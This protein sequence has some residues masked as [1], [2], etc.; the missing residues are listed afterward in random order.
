MNNKQHT[1]KNSIFFEG[2]GLH[3]GTYSKIELIPAL[4]NTGIIFVRKDIP[5]API[6]KVDIDTFLNAK[7]FLRRTS[8]GKEGIYI[9][10]IEHLMAAFHIL[11][12]DNVYINIW[13]EEIPGL[14]GSSK[15]FVEEILKVGMEEQDVT[16]EYIAVNDIIHI[17]ENSASITVL[18][19]PTLRISY[20]LKYDN[21]IIG[22]EYEEIIIPSEDCI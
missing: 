20:V 18:P 6:I 12:I 15:E 5:S 1:I 19:Y 11:G 9:H 10:T 4:P 14:D 13:G 3:T 21:P 22:S 8:I 2:I 7:N 17:E 16:R